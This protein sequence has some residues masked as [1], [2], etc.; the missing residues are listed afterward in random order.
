M[1]KHNMDWWKDK[2]VEA[3]GSQNV[4]KRLIKGVGDVLAHRIEQLAEA[5]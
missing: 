3:D 5:R 1:G 2:E 4:V